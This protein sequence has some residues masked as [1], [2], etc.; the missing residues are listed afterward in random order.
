MKPIMK[1]RVLVPSTNLS[2]EEIHKWAR[3]FYA[4]DRNYLPEEGTYDY[5]T[6]E[7]ASGYDPSRI[8]INV[9]DWTWIPNGG[10][11]CKYVAY[12]CKQGVYIADLNDN[13]DV[14]G[15]D[16]NG[17]PESWGQHK[18]VQVRTVTEYFNSPCSVRTMDLLHDN[19]LDVAR[20]F[21][22]LFQ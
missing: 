3:G 13:N 20:G 9:H 16:F 19:T 18:T 15:M 6:G 11:N 7:K 17:T 2:K 21:L 10:Y 4:I 22:K 8:Y 14:I 5:M 1:L 12:M